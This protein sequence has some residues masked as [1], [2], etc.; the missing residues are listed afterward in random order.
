M[1]VRINKSAFNIR[2][3]LSE[4]ERPIG[5]KG[6]ELMRA[7]TAQEAR[8]L[9]SAG[10]KNLI[11]NGDMRI[12]QRGT[13]ANVPN[14]GQIGT[15]DRWNS[16]INYNTG[17]VVMSQETDAPAGFHKSLKVV[18]NDSSTPA[19]Y[20]FLGQKI[21]A[22]SISQL[23]TGTSSAK[24]FTI[25]FWVKSNRPGTYNLECLDDDGSHQLIKQ[26]TINSSGVWEYKT[27]TFPPNTVGGVPTYDNT[28]GLDLN[29]WLSSNANTTYTSGS[30]T[31]N[32]A[33]YATNRRNAGGNAI[34]DTGQYWMITGVQ[35][36][37]G[38]NATEFEHR[39]FG[40][41]LALCQRYYLKYGMDDL[42]G[43]ESAYSS[44]GAENIHASTAIATGVIVDSDDALLTMH[45]PVMMRARPS[46]NIV[47]SRISNG[48][49]YYNNATTIQNNNSSRAMFSALVDNGGTMTAGQGAVLTIKGN[50]YIDLDAEL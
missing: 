3:K 10:R 9:V 30:L 18:R 50:G 21:E 27:I 13:S 34:L 39:S 5:L 20:F 7:E 23:G 32:W 42:Y 47:D 19:Q 15:V 17:A 36:E 4:L 41:E 24:P 48:A 12:A 11:I 6:S 31:D 16:W 1:T 37:V 25:S 44:T 46:V 22:Q 38:K 8:D 28:L 35:L 49:T 40:E 2:E 14:L 29:W 43:I 33:A 45:L 26:Y